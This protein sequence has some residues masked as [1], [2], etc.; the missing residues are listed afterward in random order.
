M[1]IPN[2]RVSILYIQVGLLNIRIFI[3]SLQDI[4]IEY[5]FQ[6]TQ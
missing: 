2:I 4:F 6:C 3:A 5:F 1:V